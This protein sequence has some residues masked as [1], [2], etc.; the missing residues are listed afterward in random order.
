MSFGTSP[1]FDG[2]ENDAARVNVAAPAPAGKARAGEA[3]EGGSVASGSGAPGYLQATKTSAY[4]SGSARKAA[5]G[6]LQ[7]ASGE[8]ADSLAPLKV[9]FGKSA[10]GGAAMK[11]GKHG[12]F[13]MAGG[14]LVDE[15]GEGHDAAGLGHDDDKLTKAKVAAKLPE[16]KTARFGKD[17]YLGVAADPKAPKREFLL[18]HEP[19][20]EPSAAGTSAFKGKA[21]EDRAAFLAPSDKDLHACEGMGQLADCARGAFHAQADN[22]ATNAV[23][24]D[25]TARFKDIKLAAAQH[26]VG[27]ASPAKPSP[28]K[29]ALVYKKDNKHGRF[30]EFGAIYNAK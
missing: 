6:R 8:G 21:G 2:V 27:L 24:K 28:S 19:L 7:F 26:S 14:Y 11:V 4:K 29:A 9:D 5:G 17:S 20:A 10:K 25:Q 22:T 15:K 18:A 30:S 12:R 13:S 1:R 23:F 3:G 16:Q